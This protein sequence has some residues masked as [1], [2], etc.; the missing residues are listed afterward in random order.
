MKNPFKNDSHSEEQLK[1]QQIEFRIHCAIVE[2]FDSAFPTAMLW[3]T[4]N[5]PGNATDGFFK[6]KMGSRRGA[7]DLG[8]SWNNNNK[9]ECGWYEVKAPGNYPT[10]HQ[11]KWMSAFSHLGWITAWGTSV[12]Q[13]FNTFESWGIPRR[14]YAV[15]EP[16][17]RH[18][19]EKK[20]DSF[21]FFMP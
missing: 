14:H 20:S 3:H 9:L 10:P 18:D 11:N 5:R 1:Y 7:S 21:K 13:A 16:D 2:Q 19:V 12:T 4:P 8:L 17:L 15:E 6:Q